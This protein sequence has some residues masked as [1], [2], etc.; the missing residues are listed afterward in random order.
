MSRPL[1]TNFFNFTKIKLISTGYSAHTIKNAEA[2]VVPSKENGLE[3]NADKYIVITR[4]QNAGRRHNTEIDNTSFER[5]E[6]LKYL[7][8]SLTYQNSIQKE[9]KSRLK[10]GNAFCH[11]VQN[12]LSSNEL[13][14][15]LK[16]KI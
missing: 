7:E 15:N 16:I 5:V 8:T 1:R 9:N 6:D 10:S 11:S 12:L 3:V 13:T 14:K 4:D 2:L